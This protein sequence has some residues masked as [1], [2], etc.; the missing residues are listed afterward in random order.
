MNNYMMMLELI[1]RLRQVCDHPN[2]ALKNQ[3]SETTSS[4]RGASS[5]G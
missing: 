5:L 1:L 3:G 2:L 4:L